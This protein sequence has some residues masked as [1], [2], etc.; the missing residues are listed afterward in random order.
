[1][2]K[3]SLFLS[4]LFLLI[5]SS[6]E[7][8]QKLPETR[9]F[10]VGVALD[11]KNTNV[12][13]LHGTL[14]DGYEMEK[15]FNKNAQ[16]CNEKFFNYSLYQEGFDHDEDTISSP[17]YPSKLNILSAFDDISNK[18]EIT[19]ITIFYFSGHG[20]KDDGALLCGTT[21]SI[22][23]KSMTDINVI[24]D[25]YLL[26]PIEIKHKMS[27]IKGKKLIIVDSCYSG[28]FY[29]DSDDTVDIS[30]NDDYYQSSFEKFFGDCEASSD[31]DIFI[32]CATE[33]DNFS[34]EPSSLL[35]S[36]PHGYFTRA[37]LEGIG[38][39]YGEY[40]TVTNKTEESVVADDG[41]QG[42]LCHGNPPACYSSN[43]LSI[44]NLYRYIKENQNIPLKITDG[45]R[46][47]QHPRVTSGRKDLIL[48]QY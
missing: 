31:K 28:N 16:K 37:L 38:W 19:D 17:N 21:D 40:G 12:N 22:G 45:Q 24:D 7:L 18:A 11:Y 25:S 15:A 43:S 3:T 26:S 41:I 33:N 36:H 4:L 13:S 30:E 27:K 6:C 46:S 35:H 8:K 23:G 48:F 10:Y 5:L 44:D 39:N 1:M 47:H 14:N 34:H 9:I 29:S 20:S 2:K 32:L 42:K